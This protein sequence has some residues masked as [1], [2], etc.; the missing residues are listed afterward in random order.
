MKL[1]IYCAGGFG[2]EIMD[3]VKKKNKKENR[4]EDIFFI[5]DIIKE[6]EHYGVN[7][8]TFEQVI[9]N[10]PI[11]SFEVSIASG[12]P[13]V[14]K[15]LY[16]KIKSYNIKLSTIIDE[17]A[18]VSDSAEIGEGVIIPAYSFVSSLAKIGNNSTLYINS[19]VSHEVI[20]SENCV[21]ASGSIITGGSYID[22]NTYVGIGA[23]IRERIK[24]DKGVIIGMGS[25]VCN[26]I[27]DYT[28]AFGNPAS[29]IKKNSDK[30]VFKR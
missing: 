26:D 8:Y 24:I 12:E 7:K 2:K 14:R 13:F 16:E 17:T 19:I 1:F 5:D 29:P 30:R 9:S 3:M 10:F 20:I 23:N 28:I 25:I 22:K 21:I 18:I 11:G 27:D 4:W 6:D 15:I